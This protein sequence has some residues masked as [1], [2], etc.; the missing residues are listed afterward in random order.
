MSVRFDDPVRFVELSKF[1]HFSKMERLQFDIEEMR[2]TYQS[3]VEKYP[4]EDATK[5]LCLT[6]RKDSPANE[7][8]YDGCGSLTYKWS[9]NPYD[10]DGE[11]KKRETK[12]F[13]KDFTEFSEDL[14][15]TYFFEIYKALSEV[16]HI[17][18]FRFMLMLTSNEQ[19]SGSG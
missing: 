19:S 3:I 7:L 10:S 12:L 2:A 16:F 5:Q 4:L 1:K 17:G 14:K 11:L 6:H 8:L 15:N 13:D 18:R 9:K